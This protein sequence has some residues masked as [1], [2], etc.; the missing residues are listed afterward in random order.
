MT[1]N[2]T[3]DQ[4]NDTEHYSA[5]HSAAIR[6]RLLPTVRGRLEVQTYT[7]AAALPVAGDFVGQRAHTSDY[8]V[9]WSWT[10]SRWAPEPWTHFASASNRD[11]AI[12][13]P[14]GGDSCTVG[15]NTTLRAF[16][17]D[18]T[19]WRQVVHAPDA[20]ASLSLTNGTTGTGAVT[21]SVTYLSQSLVRID[22]VVTFGTGGDVTGTLLVNLPI[23]LGLAQAG[24]A[25]ARRGSGVPIPL[26]C[27]TA[28]VNTLAFVTTSNN[29]IVGQT[30]PQDWTSGDILAGS[31][32][33]KVAS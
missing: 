22:F 29:A 7:S 26:L 14:S 32:I 12:P 25:Y 17:H 10:G 11:S 1:V 4:F 20:T 16:I 31:I 30:V 6:D 3:W 21:G 33:A 19:A 5:S 28:S 2:H 27:Y 23:S 8:G 24:Q 15:A 18:G 9:L 13:S